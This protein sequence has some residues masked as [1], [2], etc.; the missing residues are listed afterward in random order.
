[1]SALASTTPYPTAGKPPRRRWWIPVSVRMF[2]GMLVILALACCWIG[3]PVC[4]QQMAIWDIERVGG[5]VE[6]E[7]TGPRWLRE[8]IS[9]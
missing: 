3:A 8:I 9:E 4:R 6:V 7:P 1:M 2:L 5:R